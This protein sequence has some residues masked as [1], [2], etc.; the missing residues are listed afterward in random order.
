MNKT[1]VRAAQGIGLTEAQVTESRKKHGANILSVRPQK[2]FLAHFF[3]NLGDPV[4]KIL[5]CA[6]AVNLIFVFYGGDILETVGL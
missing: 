1:G 3:S 6:L 2:S 4:I 5:L